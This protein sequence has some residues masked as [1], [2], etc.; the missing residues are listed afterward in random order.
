M[1]R[2]WRR[3]RIAGSLVTALC[4]DRLDYAE[5][6]HFN[7]RMLKGVNPW[8]WLTVGPLNRGYVSPVFLP[9]AGPCLHCL[10]THFQRLSPAPELY[11]DL[12]EHARRGQPICAAPFPPQGVAI[13]QQLLLWK[14]ALLREPEAPAALFQ[15]HVL[16]IGTL[17]VTAHRVYRD[18][19]CSACSGR[20]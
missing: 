20:R 10:L 13:L 15:L 2:A 9:D 12:K 18:P 3:T 5:A 17:E 4:Q 19:E 6:L 16:E 7:A 8:L 11:D 14:V 1:L